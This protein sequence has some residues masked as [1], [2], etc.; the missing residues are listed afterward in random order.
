[1]RRVAA[2][3]HGG[4][5][6][7]LWSPVSALG[8]LAAPARAQTP[9]WTFSAGYE[10]LRIPDE[11][12]PAGINADIALR[13]WNLVSELSPRRETLLRALFTDHPRPYAE[14]ARSCGIPPG[15]IGPTRA[16]ALA[17]LRDKLEQHGFRPGRRP[18]T[19]STLRPLSA[20][21]QE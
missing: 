5:G 21:I 9:R 18:C 7:L 4:F 15:G 11:T 13:L 10:L 19:S 20:T 12:F 6:W 14:V 8:L 16:R 3:G 17:Q 2:T 1:M